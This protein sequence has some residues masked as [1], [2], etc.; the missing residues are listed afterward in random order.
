LGGGRN[1]GRTPPAPRPRRGRGTRRRSSPDLAGRCRCSRAADGGTASAKRPREPLTAGPVRAPRKGT[2]RTAAGPR[3]ARLQP[4]IRQRFANAVGCR[5]GRRAV[6]FVAR[7][8]RVW[9]GSNSFPE[10]VLAL[11]EKKRPAQGSTLHERGEAG[12]PRFS[13]SPAP[14]GNRSGSPP[15]C[16]TAERTTGLSAS[17]RLCAGAFWLSPARRPPRRPRGAP[18]AR[19]RR[20][21]CPS[22]RSPGGRTGAVRG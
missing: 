19:T 6:H 17:P 20:R 15:G 11:A 3:A 8:S 9:P 10:K 12:R 5:G 14:S 2:I 18:S 22:P 1:R 4:P 16:G 21:A 7:T 13:A